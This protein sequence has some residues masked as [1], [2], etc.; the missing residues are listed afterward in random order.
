MSCVTPRP[1]AWVSTISKGG[2]HNLAPFSYFNAVTSKPPL[3]SIAIGRRGGKRKDTADNASTTRELVVNVVTEPNLDKMVLTSGEY[4]PEVDEIALAGLTPVASVKVK[5]PRIAEAPISME[6]RTREIFEVSPG[7]VDLVIA[8]I[9]L[10]HIADTLPVDERLSIPA[11]LLRPV[12]RLG[13]ID[14]AFLGEIKK[15]PRP[16]GAGG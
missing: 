1:I 11:E 6:C 4:P 3:L 14:Y 2:V 12:G 13:G 7:I 16:D 8:E 9:V 5:P 15:V 10:F